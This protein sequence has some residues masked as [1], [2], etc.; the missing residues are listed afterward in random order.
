VVVRFALL[1]GRELTPVPVIDGVVALAVI[2]KLCVEV[3]VFA[4]TGAE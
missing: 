4:V 1:V 2:E 3:V